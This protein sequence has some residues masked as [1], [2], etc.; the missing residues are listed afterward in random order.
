M[1]RRKVYVRTDL[2]IPQ[3]EHSFDQQG[4]VLVLSQAVP[5][6]NT[7]VTFGRNATSVRSFDFARWYGSGIDSITY[8]C[9]TQ[10]ERFLA[11]QDVEIQVSS[12]T[13][14]CREGLRHFFDCLVLRG[15]ALEREMTLADIDRELIDDYLGHLAGQGVTISTQRVRYSGTKCVLLALG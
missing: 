4:R 6:A 14:A 10:I 15:T 2:S 5:P 11:G 12:I 7:L 13:A 8:A 1:G 9:Q 3:V